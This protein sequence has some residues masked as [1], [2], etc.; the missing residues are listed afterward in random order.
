MAGEKWCDPPEDWQAPSHGLAVCATPRSGSNYLAELIGFCGDAGRPRE[1]F[2]AATEGE[3]PLPADAAAWMAGVRTRGSSSNGRFAIKLFPTH[4]TT[5]RDELGLDA[6]AWFP[7]LRFVHL[8]RRDL[9][10]QAVSLYLAVGSG[11][12]TSHNRERPQPDYDFAE[13]LRLLDYLV[14]W[15][16]YW[17]RLFALTDR[18]PLELAYEDL[19][20]D[21]LT[22]LNRIRRLLELPE[23]GPEALPK[24]IVEVQ[25]T[26][27]NEDYRNRFLADV[28][29]GGYR[30]DDRPRRQR[31]GLEGLKIL[32]RDGLWSRP[33]GRRAPPR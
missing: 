21:P 5:L 1:H 27:L 30:L 29:A 25:R 3:C 14:E 20:A 26:G 6:L 8:R 11:A 13:L 23:R 12:W 7:G 9:L 18:Q 33:L 24:P 2:R 4:L 32:C 19:V 28:A 10:S 17:R 31:F 16:G 22:A 15:D